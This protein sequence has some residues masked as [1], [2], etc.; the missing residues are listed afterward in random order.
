M[1]MKSMCS[2]MSAQDAVAP[3]GMTEQAGNVS[4]FMHQLLTRCEVSDDMRDLLMSYVEANLPP[5]EMLRE[6]EAED[7]RQ[8]FRE[9]F[10]AEVDMLLAS[11]ED[12]TLTD[13]EVRSFWQAHRLP[14]IECGIEE[15]GTQTIQTG[16]AFN[17]DY[18]AWMHSVEWTRD[19]I[20]S[21][22][23]TNFVVAFK[24]SELSAYAL[25]PEVTG[26]PSDYP[27]GMWSYTAL[28]RSRLPLGLL[29]RLMQCF[30]EDERVQLPS[31]L[32]DV[33][34]SFEEVEEGERKEEGMV[35]RCRLELPIKVGIER[36]IALGEETTPFETVPA[37]FPEGNRDAF[38]QAAIMDSSRKVLA[39][40]EDETDDMKRLIRR[41]FWQMSRC[42]E[43]RPF[44]ILE[45]LMGPLEDQFQN[46]FGERSAYSGF[47]IEDIAYAVVTDLATE[48][49]A[50]LAKCH[51]YEGWSLKD[52]ECL[53]EPTAEEA[54]GFYRVTL[55]ND[56]VGAARI[57][58]NLN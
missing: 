24:E 45:C 38:F 19:L 4:R 18:P 14:F 20:E 58:L 29:E 17:D 26:R 49:L 51:G 21:L 31:V 34:V 44:N 27:C 52:C 53:I 25:V 5:S 7:C 28:F 48:E 46:T 22:I 50:A 2:T 3:A 15:Y 33:V 9:A 32:Q 40:Y 8:C 37:S 55:K 23:P 54:R 1:K 57:R 41:G 43:M 47:V 16:A 13:E 10:N 35:Y 56:R 30:M 36:P 12:G 42:P 6:D 39:G 11:F